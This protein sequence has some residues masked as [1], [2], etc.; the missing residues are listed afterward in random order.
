MPD[1]LRERV[2][3][4][5]RDI[6]WL[7]AQAGAAPIMDETP[8]R[9]TVER[10]LPG[11]M[12]VSAGLALVHGCSAA[13]QPLPDEVVQKWVAT[14]TRTIARW[15]PLLDL[16]DIDDLMADSSLA[17]IDW[18]LARVYAT[19]F[20]GCAIHEAGHGWEE[21]E[22]NWDNVP[23]KVR[24]L[25]LQLY[26]DAMDGMM[27]VLHQGEAY[28]DYPLLK[29]LKHVATELVPLVH[30]SGL[31]QWDWLASRVA[32]ADPTD[33]L[34]GAPDV[35]EALEDV[36]AAFPDLTSPHD[37]ARVLELLYLELPACL[38]EGPLHDLR[39][40]LEKRL[41]MGD[42]SKLQAATIRRRLRRLVR[43]LPEDDSI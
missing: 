40:A 41:G 34:F 29:A 27:E 14:L 8:L 37:M 24:L 31:P 12:D 22:P 11:L 5:H 16:G 42:L 18:G 7:A 17:E 10:V 21:W 2:D 39:G 43:S 20:Q 25:A 23:P 38:L 1:D 33:G 4:I 6:E 30:G 26:Q 3:C 35:V 36:V 32:K 28:I 9:E 19:A 13:N 15:A